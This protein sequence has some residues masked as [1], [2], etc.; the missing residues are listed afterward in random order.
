MAKYSK[1]AHSID[2]FN[3]NHL[4]ANSKTISTANGYLFLV[5]FV[6]CVCV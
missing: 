5:K 2:F 4:N 3:Q 1:H 6:L